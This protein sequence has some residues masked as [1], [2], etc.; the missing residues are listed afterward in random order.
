MSYSEEKPV[1]RNLRCPHCHLDDLAFVA[2]YHKAYFLRFIRSVITFFL[3]LFVILLFASALGELGVFILKLFHG[4]FNSLNVP[5]FDSAANAPIIQSGFF[6]TLI[7]MF[8]LVRSTLSG[9]ITY[10]ESKT[11]VQAI[12]RVCGNLWLLN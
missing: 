6:S 8:Y 7:I 11:H 4:L 3:W 12:C 2:E 1:R 10:I 9:Y 5:L